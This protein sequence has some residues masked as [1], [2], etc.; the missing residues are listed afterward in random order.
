MNESIEQ[1]RLAPY[2]FIVKNREL[3]LNSQRYEK[4]LAVIT[5]KGHKEI[6]SLAGGHYKSRTNRN[7]K[8]VG[9]EVDIN[10]FIDRAHAENSSRSDD[11]Q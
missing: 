1:S 10:V 9:F 2:N 5:T 7:P 3:N 11:D 4:A 8:P 6:Y